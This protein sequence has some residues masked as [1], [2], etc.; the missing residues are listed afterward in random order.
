MIK[1]IEVDSYL[2]HFIQS[3][4]IE[5]DAFCQ[6]G[7]PWINVSWY[8]NISNSF[9]FNI[10]L[11]T[12]SSKSL[13]WY[14]IIRFNTEYIIN[15]FWNTIFNV[16]NWN[17]EHNSYWIDHIQEKRWYGFETRTKFTYCCNFLLGILACNWWMKLKKILMIIK[18]MDYIIF[19]WKHTIKIQTIICQYHY[20]TYF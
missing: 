17:I 5:E 18:L 4:S 8:T 19:Q 2:V 14:I 12:I 16:T 11:K 9:N 15:Y 6:G 10:F 13:S 7:F 3:T 1:Q 20:H